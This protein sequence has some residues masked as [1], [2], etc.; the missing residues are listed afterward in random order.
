MGYASSAE[1]L[2]LCGTEDFFYVNSRRSLCE[3]AKLPLVIAIIAPSIRR[4]PSAECTFSAE[5]GSIPNYMPDFVLSAALVPLRGAFPLGKYGL[6]LEIRVFF[7]IWLKHHSLF[8]YLG[9]KLFYKHGILHLL[10]YES[11]FC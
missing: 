6:F 4:A 11:I 10:A 2:H 8:G 5:Q 3:T 1:C 9:Q 7:P